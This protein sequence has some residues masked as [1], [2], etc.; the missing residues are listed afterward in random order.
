MPNNFTQQT[1]TFLAG[2]HRSET[3]LMHEILKEHPQ[4]SVFSNAGFPEG[5]GQ[6]LQDVSPAAKNYGGPGKYIFDERV[7]M[8]EAHDLSSKES[9]ISVMDKWSQYCDMSCDCLIEKPAPNFN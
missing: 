6:F 3:S 9:A 2:H 4:I 1:M 5:E 7:Y 8:N